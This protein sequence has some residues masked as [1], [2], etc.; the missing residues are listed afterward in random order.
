VVEVAAQA[1]SAH[2]AAPVQASLPHMPAAAS[3][4]PSAAEEAEPPEADAGAGTAPA[5]A[6]HAATASR[7]PW[8]ADL[9]PQLRALADTL[10]ASPTP[11][12]PEA[13]AE[14]F[15]GRGPWKKSLPN[16]LGVLESL[17]RAQRV[18]GEAGELWA[19]GG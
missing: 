19:A 4:T 1:S 15:T 3:P 8:P 18:G 5:A 17:G 16:L 2:A 12:S 11:L 14:R 7:Q 9:A 10:A 6:A 13:L